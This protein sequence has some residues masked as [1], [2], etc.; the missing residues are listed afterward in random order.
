MIVNLFTGG[1]IAMRHDSPVAGVV[2]SLSATEILAA[3]RGIEAV[4]GVET[5]EWGKY[6]GPHMTVERMWALR[7][8]IREHLARP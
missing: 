6:P 7:N 1:T 2:P 5:E 4:T 3:T 8:R